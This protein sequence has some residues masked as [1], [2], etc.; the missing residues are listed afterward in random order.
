MIG[1]AVLLNIITAGLTYGQHHTTDDIQRIIQRH[2][3]ACDI[4]KLNS[5][6]LY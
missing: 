3:L 5:F 2:S 6:Q 4:A 1:S